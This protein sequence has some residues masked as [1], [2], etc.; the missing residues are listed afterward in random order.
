MRFLFHFTSFEGWNSIYLKTHQTAN[1]MNLQ[2]FG[3]C[4]SNPRL[5]STRNPNPPL[6]LLDI[7]FYTPSWGHCGA[8][9][10]WLCACV[11]CVSVIESQ[12]DDVGAQRKLPLPKTAGVEGG[13]GGSGACS[14]RRANAKSN[15]RKQRG[16]SN[17]FEVWLGRT[18]FA[19][20]MGPLGF[21]GRAA[22]GFSLNGRMCVQECLSVCVFMCVC[23]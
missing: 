2:R 20:I 5:P 4:P 8:T 13:R 23:V 14:S 22:S 15:H 17:E 11:S 6:L 21:W 10:V 19:L 1:F 7:F 3:F 9:I 12:L 18:P 16:A